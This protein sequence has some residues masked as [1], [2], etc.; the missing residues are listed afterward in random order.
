MLAHIHVKDKLMYIL[1]SK[2]S[3]NIA[4]LSVVQMANY[5]I[6]LVVMPVIVRVLGVELFGRISYAQNIVNYLTLLV[7]FGFEYSA[8]RQI[9]IAENDKAAQQRVFWSVM[10]IKCLLLMVSFMVLGVLSFTFPHAQQDTTL[11]W[12]TALTNVGVVLYPTWYLQGRQDIPRMAWTNFGIKLLGAVMILAVIHAA[13]QYRMYPLLLSVA[14]I[15]GGLTALVYVIRRYD[16]GRPRVDRKMVGE[17]WRLGW[18]IFVNT[19]FIS[20][21]TTA[22]LTILGLYA[23]DVQVGYFSGAQRLIIAINMCVVMPVSTAIFPRMSQMFAESQESGWRYF[24]KVLLGSVVAAGVVSVVTY[25]AAP[26]VVRIMLGAQFEPSIEV[27]RLMCPLPLLI[28]GATIL[29]VQGLY[30]IGLQRVAP[31]VGAVLAVICIGLNA[32]LIPVL[33]IR[34]AVMGWLTAELLENVIVGTILWVYH[35]R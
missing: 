16:L 30:G 21:Y 23:D 8:T 33:G 7:N 28:M 17:S 9:A 29:T 35:K 19:L 4:S 27:L 3:R 34:G 1:R 24:R 25:V 12:Y 14:N 11:Y 20:L 31:Y 5:L 15:V 13:W 32:W 22:N 26:W 18:P 2:I 10:A 6:P